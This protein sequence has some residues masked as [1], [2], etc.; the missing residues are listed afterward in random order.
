[1]TGEDPAQRDGAEPVLELR[2]VSTHYRRSS[3][4]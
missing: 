4:T 2:H 1:M 3:A